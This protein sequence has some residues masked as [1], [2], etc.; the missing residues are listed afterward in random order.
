MLKKYSLPLIKKLCAQ[1]I[2]KFD[3]NNSTT[4]ITNIASL[5]SFSLKAS[6]IYVDHE[7]DE[8]LKFWLHD[9]WDTTK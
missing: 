4:S 2:Q 3:P 6:K 8:M 7:R 9:H 5:I 1:A